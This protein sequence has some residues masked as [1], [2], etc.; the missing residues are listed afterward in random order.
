VVP[1]GPGLPVGA[2]QVRVLGLTAGGTF[3]DALTIVLGAGDRPVFLS[4]ADQATLPVGSAVAFRWTPVAGAAF[5]GFE[6]T[7]PNRTFANP[8]GTGPDPVNGFGGAGGGF[9]VPATAL[10]LTLPPGI[11]PGSYQVRAIG[12]SAAGSLVGV[13]SDAVTFVIP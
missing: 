1:L 10:S 2:Y 8:N 5:Y 6:F 7:G 9:L 13:F 12:I 3:S 4:P 11:T